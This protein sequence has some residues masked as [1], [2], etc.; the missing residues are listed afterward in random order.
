[1]RN[2]RLLVF[3]AALAVP[4]FWAGAL[5]A[6]EESVPVT[7]NAINPG[8]P[9]PGGGIPAEVETSTNDSAVVTGTVV[10][11]NC[12]LARGLEGSKYRDSAI[13]CARNGTPLTI[14]TD[15]GSLV[16]PMT[17][18]TSGNTQPDMNKLMPYAEQ[19]VTVTGKLIRRGKEHAIIIY[20]VAP[21]PEP[22]VMRTYAT[23]EVPNTQ[24][25]GR[26][27]DMGC[28]IA[29][30]NAGTSD[31]KRV[32]NCA[33]SGDPLVIIDGGRIYYPVTM[34][35]PNS[36]VGTS[37]LSSYPGQKV[38]VT[39]TVIDRGESRAIVIDKVAQLASK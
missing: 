32:G 28:W 33:A 10:G 30:G 20:K 5:W 1:M 15:A 35:M 8:D 4:F 29:M 7:N 22:K 34:T 25:V 39:G 11:T 19:R 9:G 26:V 6:T 37:L 31:P 21:A 12:W 14:L 23:K 38:R 36:P 16:Y 2:A 24:V 27:V 17:I 3:I 18:G 13:A